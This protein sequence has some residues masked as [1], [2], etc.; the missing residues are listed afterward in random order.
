MKKLEIG[1]LY[2][3]TEVELPNMIVWNNLYNMLTNKYSAD[4]KISVRKS[5][6]DYTIQVIIDIYFNYIRF[7]YRNIFD[8]NLIMNMINTY[9]EDRIYN[10]IIN[11][12]ESALKNAIYNF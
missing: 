12:V 2:N 4:V 1:K 8:N 7:N 6:Y 3:Y 11:G 9:P 5:K 10:R